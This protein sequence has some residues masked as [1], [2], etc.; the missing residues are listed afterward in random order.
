L[1]DR[2]EGFADPRRVHAQLIRFESGTDLAHTR[3]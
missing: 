2:L 1:A 3:E